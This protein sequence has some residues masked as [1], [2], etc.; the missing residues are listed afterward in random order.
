LTALITNKNLEIPLR[1]KLSKRQ[2]DILK[3]G[4]LINWIKKK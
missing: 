3:E 2:V 1:H 4:G